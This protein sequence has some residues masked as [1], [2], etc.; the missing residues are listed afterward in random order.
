MTDKLSSILGQRIG[1]KPVD[2]SGSTEPRPTT[3]PVE[4]IW[5]VEY[6]RQ[7]P[8]QAAKAIKTLQM[9]LDDVE[10]ELRQILEIVRQ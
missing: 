5:S 6:C 2:N 9:A 8:E 1:A 4:E 3:T 10:G 7:Y